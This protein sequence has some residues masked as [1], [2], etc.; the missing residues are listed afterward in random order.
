[1]PE[2]V[3]KD[4]IIKRL[5]QEYQNIW[6]LIYFLNLAEW[7]TETYMPEGGSQIRGIASAR[8]YVLIQK[9]LTDKKFIYLVKTASDLEKL[10]DFE[11]GIVRILKKNVDRYLKL[12]KEFLH[13]YTALTTSSSKM[14]A[15]AKQKNDF[16]LFAQV[17]E[18]IFTMTRQKADYLGYKSHPYDALLDEYEQG[19]TTSDLDDFFE[20]IKS[21]LLVNYQ[22][23]FKKGLQSHS[24]IED[25]TYDVKIMKRI[26][27]KV[28]NYFNT[29]YQYLRLDK[30]S[31]PFT[32]VMSIQDTRITTRYPEVNFINS[33]YSTIHEYGHALYTLQHN[34]EIELSPLFTENSLGLHESQSRF[35]EN[36]IGKS[37][38]FLRLIVG[39]LRKLNINFK[40]FQIDDFYR[41]ITTVRPS[42][43]RTEADEV[44]YNLH[45][46]IRY[47][48]EKA[49]LNGSVKISELVELWNS[50]YFEYL[51]IKP[52]NM[53][54][55]ILQDIHWS[56]GLIGYFPTYALGTVLSSIWRNQL[57]FS[58]KT[59][60]E[61]LIKSISGIKKIKKWLGI[62]IH[63]YGYTYPLE[64]LVVKIT[65]AK[66]S[67]EHWQ[68]Y[69][70]KKYPVL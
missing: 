6:A 4:R 51:G 30:S 62:N 17:L 29:D 27:E 45:I 14:W 5:L 57:E 22:E 8:L 46:I 47:E 49:L 32:S 53:S 3:V 56:C 58:L 40:K 42:L 67:P 1:V 33:L 21:F 19:I 11:K 12:P 61:N 25:K 24:Q 66:F 43:I 68:K 54:T 69:L 39:D 7:D 34:P 16:G 52:T 9:E 70:L 10:N 36:H 2:N 13:A 59:P 18:K 20:K 38:T 64:E 28:L 48:V 31:H 65:G 63:Q 50:K 35:W 23:N 55:G 44:T 37:K 60:L 15:K 41:E 26:N